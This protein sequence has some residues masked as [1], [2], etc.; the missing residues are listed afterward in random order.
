VPAWQR[1]GI[2]L[3]W[4]EYEKQGVD[5]RTSAETTAIRRR[6]CLNDDLP[7]KDEY[8]AL[9]AARIGQPLS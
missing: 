7:V 1:R 6:L 4:Q 3:S 8:R 2:G 5:P 9:V